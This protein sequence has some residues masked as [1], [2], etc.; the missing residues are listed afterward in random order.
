M[1]LNHLPTAGKKNRQGGFTLIATLLVVSL[2]TV[3]L[4][5]AIVLEQVEQ[6]ASYNDSK[7]EV[8]RQNALFSLNQALNQLQMSAGPDRRVT[9]R[10]DILNSVNAGS[11]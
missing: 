5:S 10:A 6:R 4:V 1:L 11:Q 8:A 3:L 7:I 9:A 2:L